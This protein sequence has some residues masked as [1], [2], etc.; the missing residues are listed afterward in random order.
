MSRKK[1]QV[2]R[3][4]PIK[5]MVATMWK[6]VPRKTGDERRLYYKGVY[7]TLLLVWGSFPQMRPQLVEA[8]LDGMVLE[9]EAL[10][11]DEVITNTKRMKRMSKLRQKTKS[12]IH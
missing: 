6:A 9:C 4:D 8:Y 3:L 2:R 7:D 12:T 11:S 10:F 5:N 1:K